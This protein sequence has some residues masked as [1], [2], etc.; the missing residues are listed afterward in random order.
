M[1]PGK[2][3]SLLSSSHISSWT[4]LVRTSS[5]FLLVTFSTLGWSPQSPSLIPLRVRRLGG[6][7]VLLP[8]VTHS[9]L[10]P[11]VSSN[12]Y[13]TQFWS[14]HSESPCWTQRPPR[15]WIA[16]GQWHQLGC[17]S[18]CC[19]R[20]WVTTSVL[21]RD[22]RG[23][24]P[25]LM[26]CPATPPPLLSPGDG[27]DACSG[28][29]ESSRKTSTSASLS[30]LKA[31]TAWITINWE[32]LKRWESQ[33]TLPAF[34]ETCMQVNKHQLEPDG[35]M[36]WFKIGKGVCQGCILSSCLFNLYVENIMWNVRLGAS[37]DGNKIARRNINS[38]RYAD[39]TS[40]MAEREEELKS[41]L[42][43][44]KEKSEKTG[45][46]LNIKKL[47]SWHPVPNRWGKSGN[48]DRLYFLGFQNHCRCWLQPWH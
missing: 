42:M 2:P 7:F 17:H 48:S 37:Q 6:H 41:F 22:R 19:R 35:T 47:R 3:L 45:L 16:P 29:S 44:I 33:P 28:T 8:P 36:D 5:P 20:S 13:R 25:R 9:L 10:P 23:L 21:W 11:G 34:W 32:L 15:V 24:C 18:F 26:V 43:R 38:H 39:D 30:M 4:L 12:I 27:S 1:P 40:L 14:P 46:K 31:L